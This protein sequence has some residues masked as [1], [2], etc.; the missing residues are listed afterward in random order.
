MTDTT[1]DSVEKRKYD[2]VAMTLHWLMA[3]GI[4][5]AL[6]LG[7]GMG[8]LS[9]EERR[10][11]LAGHS[12]NGLF[13]LTLAVVRLWW[14]IKNPPP[15]YPD[16]MPDWQKKTAK[17]V[18]HLFYF[19]F[20]YMPIVGI[21]HAITYQ[22]TLVEPLQLFNLTVAPGDITQVFHVMHNLGRLLFSA[23]VIIHIGAA[24]KHLVIDRDGVFQRMIPFTKP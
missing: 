5:V 17:A 22:D 12:F 15:P 2:G 16:S 21:A 24:L 13:I 3:L 9:P 4:L 19:L 1:A 11:V 14:R 7:P 18:T 20:F 23:L 10:E 8:D 6:I